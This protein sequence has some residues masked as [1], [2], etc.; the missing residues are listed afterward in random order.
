MSVGTTNYQPPASVAGLQRLGMGTALVGVVFTIV[1]LGQFLLPTRIP[2]P[3]DILLGMI[4]A[5][6]G[7]VA[8]RWVGSAQAVGGR[9]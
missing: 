4:G 2:D 8:G 3:T 1:E 7:L 5:Y 9:R 6:A